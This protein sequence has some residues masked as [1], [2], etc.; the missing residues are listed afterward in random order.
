[1][2]PEI[3]LERRRSALFESSWSVPAET[4]VEVP[5][6]GFRVRW[7]DALQLASDF[8]LFERKKPRRVSG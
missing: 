3:R 7:A 2:S 1:M 4:V 6:E 5:N 8:W